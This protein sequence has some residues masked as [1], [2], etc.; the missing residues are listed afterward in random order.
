MASWVLIKWFCRRK[1]RPF[2]K[3]FTQESMAATSSD[4]CV[5]VSATSANR[6]IRLAFAHV[7]RVGGGAG[8]CAEV[9]SRRKEASAPLASSTSNLGKRLAASGERMVSP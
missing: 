7:Y 5:V 1:N 3:S 8:L 6:N 4:V 9:R 2:L